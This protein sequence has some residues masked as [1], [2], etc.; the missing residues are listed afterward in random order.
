V[1]LE[2]ATHPGYACIGTDMGHRG[3]GGAWL[4]DNLQAQIDFSYRATHVVTLAGK[5]ITERY[6]GTKPQKSYF[7]GASTGGYQG[8]VEAQ[9]YPWDFDGI[10]AGAPDMDESD[11][12]VHDIWMERNSIG[13]DGKPLLGLE[14]L[15]LVHR[16]ALA[17][18]DMDDGVRDGIISDPLHCRFDPG[19]L[20]CKA[21][22]SS[23][24]LSAEQVQAVKNIYGAPV[25]S[26]GTQLLSRGV[27]PG[28]EIDWSFTERS[29]GLEYFQEGA[30]LGTGWKSSDF[31]FDRDYPRSGSGV[32]FPDTN[33]DLR[34]FKAAGGKLLV[35]QGA[36]DS[37]EY[38]P[39][40][41]DYYETVERTMG[42]RAATQD[43]FRLFLIPGMLHGTGGDGPYAID[44]LSYMAAWV[45]QGKPPDMMIG[46][47]PDGLQPGEE[48]LLKF[49]LDPDIHVAFT[50]PLYPYPLYARYKGK[51]D[52]NKAENFGP[53][54]P[55]L[56]R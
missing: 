31:D 11:L 38:P 53:V 46:A 41:L 10:V 19:E 30:L 49:P 27:F 6:Y 8:M 35:Y 18:C 55:R 14:D 40:L 32:L 37:A 7:M 22:G 56:V 43:F 47:H 4:R 33:P 28:S 21:D 15:K 26:S 13:S 24:C 5:A 16:A 54:S 39:A 36:N 45:E 3:S 44:Y 12:A 29:W 34:K 23:G 48:Y 50:R 42:G 2:C 1:G 25:T 20:V 17:K 52:P 9:R 51:G